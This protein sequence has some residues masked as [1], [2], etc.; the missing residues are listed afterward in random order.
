MHQAQNTCRWYHTTPN[1]LHTAESDN[2]DGNLCM[3]HEKAQTTAMRSPILGIHR[4]LS[5]LA[6]RSTQICVLQVYNKEFQ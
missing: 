1:P 3:K 2:G 4:F 6:H 5:A